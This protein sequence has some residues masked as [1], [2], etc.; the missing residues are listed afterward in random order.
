VPGCTVACV[1]WRCRLTGYGISVT[2]FNITSP[3]FLLRN[4]IIQLLVTQSTSHASN[5][6]TSNVRTN[7]NNGARSWNQCRPG[8]AIRITYSE[9]VYLA[10]VIQHAKR[11]GRIIMSSVACPPSPYFFTFYHKRH[12]FRKILLDT[13]FV[14]WLSLKLLSETFLIL[15]RI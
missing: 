9:C 6:K 15:R 7:V 14:F 10:L 3:W 2:T 5:A 8:K 1:P 12:E 11:M 4:R 13:K